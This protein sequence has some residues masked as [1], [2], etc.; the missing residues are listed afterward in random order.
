MEAPNEPSAASVMAGL[1]TRSGLASE[2]DCSDRTIIR[3]EHAGMP[4]I[5]VGIMRLYNPLAVR[6]WLMSHERRRDIPKRGR[7]SAKRTA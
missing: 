1:L 3:Y 4:V 6:D 2:L 7:P 5:R